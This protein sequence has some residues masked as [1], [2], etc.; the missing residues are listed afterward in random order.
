MAMT[1]VQVL[2]VDVGGSGVKYAL[3]DESLTLREKAGA[4]WK[5]ARDPHRSR[6]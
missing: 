1:P 6:N 3:T 4:W 2:A 5:D